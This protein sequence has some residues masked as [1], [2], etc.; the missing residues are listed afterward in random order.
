[1]YELETTWHRLI[2]APHLF[3]LQLVAYARWPKQPMCA[4]LA[5][6]RLDWSRVLMD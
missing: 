4:C 5:Q 1:M 2:F 3:T 6:K